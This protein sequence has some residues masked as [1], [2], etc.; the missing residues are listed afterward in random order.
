MLVGHPSGICEA[1]Q[2]ARKRDAQ[3]MESSQA[4]TEAKKAT[5]SAGHGHTGATNNLSLCSGLA[6]HSHCVGHPMVADGWGFLNLTP[7]P[8]P[9]LT[10]TPKLEQIICDRLYKLCEAGGTG[11]AG[12]DHLL[13]ERATE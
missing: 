8:T 1:A 6:L 4:R 5:E 11:G 10:S 12:L 2:V 7:N 9:I 3:A 13:R